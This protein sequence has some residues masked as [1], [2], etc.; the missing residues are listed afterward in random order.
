MATTF[1]QAPPRRP[2][3][4]LVAPSPRRPELHDK[5]VVE[6]LGELRDDSTL[7]VKSEMELAKREVSRELEMVQRRAAAFALSGAVAH[8]GAALLLF[9]LALVL[10]LVMPL[11]ASTLIVGVVA[12][13][14]AGLLALQ[15]KRAL[16]GHELA[17]SRAV[18]RLRN[19][20]TAIKEAAR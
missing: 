18:R 7:L 8:I 1:D 4:A 5:G 6:L 14:G 16:A 2:P 19:D 20:F 11:W 13:A 15:Q 3:A 12:C 17:P 9:G 10:G